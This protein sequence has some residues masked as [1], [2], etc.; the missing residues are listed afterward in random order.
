MSAEGFLTCLSRSLTSIILA[1][2]G[3]RGES[4]TYIEAAS[5]LLSKGFPQEE[6]DAVI[7]LLE[8]IDSVR[9][10]GREMDASNREKL[11]LETREMVRKIS[12]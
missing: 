7:R 8:N 11:L 10:S 4:L 3:I 2:A 12:K 1:R 9:F 6:T 5:I